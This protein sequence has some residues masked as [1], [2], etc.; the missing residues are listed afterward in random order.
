MNET[1]GW[2]LI[3]LTAISAGAAMLA[4]ATGRWLAA[5][6]ATLDFLRAYC[7]SPEVGRAHKILRA[8]PEENTPLKGQNRED[9]LF[10]MNMF[11]VLSIGLGCGIY[12]KRMVI[13]SFGRDLKEIWEKAKPL[14]MHMRSAEKD[15]EAF[16]EF[17]R[18]AERTRS[19]TRT[20]IR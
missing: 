13:K 8:P 10:L 11:E 12:D 1:Q 16:V 18:L 3:A 20:R 17:E 6:R 15:P 2:A 9:F 4:V 14:V 19:E 7:T 5:R